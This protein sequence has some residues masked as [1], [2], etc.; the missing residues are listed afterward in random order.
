LGLRNNQIKRFRFN[1][2]DRKI[3]IPF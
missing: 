1:P 3:E 2:L